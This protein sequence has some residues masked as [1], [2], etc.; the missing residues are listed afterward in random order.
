MS[1]KNNKSTEAVIREA[2]SSSAARA[3]GDGDEGGSLISVGDTSLRHTDVDTGGG[4]A[5]RLS[6]NA[7]GTSALQAALTLHPCVHIA[8]CGD[9]SVEVLNA[10]FSQVG[11]CRITRDVDEDGYPT[12]EASATYANA[13]AAAAAIQK[14]D[15]ERLDD[16]ELSV[17]VSKRAAQGSLT[18]RGRGK[19][20]GRGGDGM[21]FHD[22]QQDLI[23]QQMAQRAQGERDEFAAARAK[24]LAEGPT[25]PLAGPAPPPRKPSGQEPAAKKAKV[26]AR[27]APPRLPGFLAVQKVTAA[28]PAAAPAPQAPPSDAADGGGGGLLGLGGY[29]SDSDEDDE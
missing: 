14:F 15:G 26:E 21:T 11:E 12:G 8:G 2:M 1:L 20:R 27:A 18:T 23:S 16:G 3:D 25:G 29:G 22:R 5:S 4:G 6:K 17:T 28:A 10:I 9:A 7:I 13:A 24:A 19:G